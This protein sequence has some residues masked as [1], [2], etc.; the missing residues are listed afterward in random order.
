MGRA[1]AHIAPIERLGRWDGSGFRP[2]EPGSVRTRSILV[3]SHGW[4]PGLR[5]VIDEADGFVRVWD[6]A[7]TTSRGDRFDPWYGPLATAVTDIIDDVALLG[8][9]WVDESATGTSN[10]GTACCCRW[11]TSGK[12]RPS[13]VPRSSHPSLRRSRSGGRR[14]F[15][16]HRSRR[17]RSSARGW[18]RSRRRS[19]QAQ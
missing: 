13:C 11:G 2:I 9:T 16:P 17:L 19:R 5:S 18:Y 12:A 10:L 6:E 3:M 15:T 1:R 8:F 14:R 4:A 7:A